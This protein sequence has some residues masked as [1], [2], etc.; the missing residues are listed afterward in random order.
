MS[1]NTLVKHYGKNV[2]FET[3]TDGTKFMKARVRYGFRDICPLCKTRISKHNVTS[4][5]LVV[6][7]QV[8]V[9]NRI[10]HSECYDK[11]LPEN[12]WNR[13]F[14]DWLTAQKHKDWFQQYE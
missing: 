12:I 9:P 13:I 6:S 4:V 3:I 8:G 2:Y 10:L 11:G 14:C 7:N 5:V 1:E